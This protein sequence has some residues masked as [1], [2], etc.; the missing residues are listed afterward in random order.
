MR[1]YNKLVRDRIPEI[2]RENNDKA[3]HHKAGKE[4]FRKKLKEKLQ[5]EVEELI[6]EENKEEIAD[7]FEVLDAILDFRDIDKEEIEKIKRKKVEERGKFKDRIILE[8][9]E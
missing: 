2:C 4:E 8:K 6:E 9:T 5:E 1:K 3:F 7:I